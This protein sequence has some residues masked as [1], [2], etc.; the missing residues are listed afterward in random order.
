MAIA[1]LDEFSRIQNLQDILEICMEE[2]AEPSKNTQLRT[3]QLLS[4]YRTD[5]RIHLND[6]SGSLESILQ[7]VIGANTAQK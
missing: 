3:E 4:L 7:L 2:L 6:L 1:A 5:M